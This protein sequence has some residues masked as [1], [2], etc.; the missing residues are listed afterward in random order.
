MASSG[1]VAQ[2]GLAEAPGHQYCSRLC[3]GGPGGDTAGRQPRPCRPGHDVSSEHHW[4]GA[5]GCAA[6]YQARS[7]DEQ[8][9]IQTHQI[10]Q[11]M[12]KQIRRQALMTGT[13]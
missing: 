2:V 12:D 10:N 1:H 3:N 9:S 13:P 8:A 4:R 6:G 7:A 5:V 11:Y